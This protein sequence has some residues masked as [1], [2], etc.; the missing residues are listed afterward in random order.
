MRFTSTEWKGKQTHLF[1]VLVWSRTKISARTSSCPSAIE[2]W[3]RARF[4]CPR[5]DLGGKER[6]L[7]TL[8]GKF[9]VCDT[10]F[11]LHP[12]PCLEPGAC[13]RVGGSYPA[14]SVRKPEADEGR[15]LRM[16]QGHRLPAWWPRCK[17]KR[18]LQAMAM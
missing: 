5:A 15:Q 10:C 3:P 1:N 11:A 12:L 8:A 6:T 13:F 4:L 16:L 14:C 9:C 7:I 17:M 18:V 2:V